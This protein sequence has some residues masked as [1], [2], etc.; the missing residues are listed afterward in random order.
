MKKPFTFL[1]VFVAVMGLTKCDLS[2]SEK[3]PEPVISGCWKLITSSYINGTY[4]SN[5]DMASSGNYMCLNEDGTY[6]LLIHYLECAGETGTYSITGDVLI[7]YGDPV[8]YDCGDLKILTK[9]KTDLKIRWNFYEDGTG[10]HD[11]TFVKQQ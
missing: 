8:D 2:K 3:E 7:L 4:Q 10:Y 6:E 1:L 5:E 11:F 9:T